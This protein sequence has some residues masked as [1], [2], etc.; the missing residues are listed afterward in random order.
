MTHLGP[1]ERNRRF[2]FLGAY[3]GTILAVREAMLADSTRS[4]PIWRSDTTLQDVIETATAIL[5]APRS[6]P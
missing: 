1:A 2:V 4:H 6:G 3:L 5:T